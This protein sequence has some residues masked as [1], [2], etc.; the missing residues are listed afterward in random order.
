MKEET[1]LIKM[2]EV[3]KKTRNNGDKKNKKVELY[4]K[5]PEYRENVSD[6][7]GQGTKRERE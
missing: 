4:K 5:Q 6:L 3:T 7:C 1:V 2:N